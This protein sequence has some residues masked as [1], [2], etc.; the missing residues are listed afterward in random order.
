[1][2]A[3]RFPDIECVRDFEIALTEKVNSGEIKAT[4]A[5]KLSHSLRQFINELCCSANIHLQEGVSDGDG[6][7]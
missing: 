4:Y 1:M 6:N 2:P 7:I 5:K 3:S